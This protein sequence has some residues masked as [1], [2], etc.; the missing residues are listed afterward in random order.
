MTGKKTKG[1][2]TQYGLAKYLQI[3]RQAVNGALKSGRLELDENKRIDPEN[4]K[5]IEFIKFHSGLIKASGQNGRGRPFDSGN[6]EEFSEAEILLEK[7]KQGQD[8]EKRALESIAEQVKATDLH[9]KRI[10]AAKEQVFYHE[11]IKKVI[12]FEIA[13]RLFNM[14]SNAIEQEFRDFD[15]KHTDTIMEA[16]KADKTKTEVAEIIRKEIEAGISSVKKSSHIAI[17]Q[18]REEWQNEGFEH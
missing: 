6:R 3:S 10:K 17:N 4:P 11:L 9:L 12:P 7:N 2:L 8:T 14:I 16:V 18:L 13:A 5:T 15:Q 1:T